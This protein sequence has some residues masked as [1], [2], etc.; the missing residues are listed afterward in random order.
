[1]LS[2][3]LFVAVMLVFVSKNV[4]S[5]SNVLGIATD[6]STQKLF[7]LTNEIRAQQGLTQLQE[8]V[9]L[10]EAAKKKASHMFQKDYWSHFAPD[11]TSPWDFIKQSGYQYEF[12]G[13]NLA[14]NFLFSNNVVDA[15]M[16]S[17]THKENIVR[18][19]YTQVGYA[20]VNG[21]LNGE[22]TT[23]VVQ[24]FG[25][26]LIK[27]SDISQTTPLPQ[28][29]KTV[30]Q[31]VQKPK[32]LGQSQKQIPTQ[33]VSIAVNGKHLAYDINMIFIA[34]IVIALILDFSVASKLNILHL[35]GKH[36]AHLLFLGFISLGILFIL[37]QGAI[38]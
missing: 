28:E 37:K 24:M 27:T 33:K 16:N 10:D 34:F 6:I 17:P 35:R 31:D 4:P 21:V 19:E 20:V 25:T 23:L 2:A 38:L 3:Y 18:K 30:M 7:M 13:E 29:E 36:V 12:A 15:W 11:G 26:P 14:K 1:M 32:V 9:Q 8:N 22:E 5:L